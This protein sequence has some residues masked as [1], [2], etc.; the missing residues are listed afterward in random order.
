MWLSRLRRKRLSTFAVNVVLFPFRLWMH[1]RRS[2][3]TTSVTLLLMIIVTLNIVWGYP[4]VGLFAACVAISI[5]GAITNRVFTP[6]MRVDVKL[7][8]SVPATQPFIVQIHLTNKR[9]LPAMDLRVGF[10]IVTNRRFDEFESRLNTGAP[11]PSVVTQPPKPLSLVRSRSHESVST[12]LCFAHRGIHTVPRVIVDSSFP[13]HLFRIVRRFKTGTQI[14]ITPAPLSLAQASLAQTM[15]KS[16]D[17]LTPRASAGDSL[18][19]TGSREYQDG[20]QVRR[21]DFGSWARLGKPIVREYQASALQTVWL[22]V[23]TAIEASVPDLD[24][25]EHVERVLSCAAAVIPEWL[26][27]KIRLRMYITS[28]SPHDGKNE[29]VSNSVVDSEPLQIRLAAASAID[30][31]TADERLR[32]MID[33]VANKPTLVL[34][35]RRQLPEAISRSPQCKVVFCGVTDSQPTSPKRSKVG[36]AGAL[37]PVPLVLEAKT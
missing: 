22:I 3:T 10:N 26:E 11:L 20:V 35:S 17:E 4:W 24:A 37:V 27:R 5:V 30:H 15:M 9:R 21:W 31:I 28:E 8:L 2:M 7:P 6:S 12:S 13:F 29:H 16:I 18:E 25:I 19:Y 32:Q 14:A 34:T 36:R 1:L 23:D 33:C